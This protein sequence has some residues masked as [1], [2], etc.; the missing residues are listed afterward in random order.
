MAGP[1]GCPISTSTSTGSGIVNWTRTLSELAHD[2]A[3]ASGNENFKGVYLVGQIH[4]IL[5]QPGEWA[6]FATNTFLPYYEELVQAS[7]S[8]LTLATR[9]LWTPPG[10]K[11]Q[12]NQDFPD[13]TFQAITCG[14]SI[15]QDNITTQAVFDELVRVVKD[16]SPMFGIQFPQPT[17]YCHRW[18]SRAVERFAGPWNHTL[19]NPIIVIGNK[20]DPTTPF[21]DAVEVAGF[22]GDS[23]VL[24]EQDGLGHSSLVQKSTCTQNIITNFFVN[25]VVPKG[26]DTVCPID[27]DGP[28]LFPTKGVRASDIKNALSNDG[29]NSGSDSQELADL[30]ADKKNLTIAVIALGA[31]CSMLITSLIVSFI[32]RRRKRGYKPVGSRGAQGQKVEFVGYDRPYS[33]RDSKH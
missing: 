5:Y 4:Q 28:P 16:V 8:D 24:V 25:G 15:D 3:R 32:V 10:L 18:A 11:R 1:Y 2:Y 12:S 23:A 27:A 14:D 13:Y 30:K 21:A 7:G 26:D 22:L 20:A 9:S 19:K 31:A 17:H 6:D 29:N 33:D